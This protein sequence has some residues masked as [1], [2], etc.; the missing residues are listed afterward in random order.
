MP[1]IQ[2]PIHHPCERARRRVLEKRLHFLGRRRQ[3]NEVEGGSSDERAP[4]GFG[5]GP[6]TP[7][8]HARQQKRIHVGA[9]PS[10][11]A[12][13]GRRTILHRLESPVLAALLKLRAASRHRLRPGAAGRRL[14]AGIGR[15]HSHPLHKVGHLRW[16]QTTRGRHLEFLVPVAHAANEQAVVGFAG[17]HD[18][19]RR[20]PFLPSPAPI[21]PQPALLLGG[22]VAIQTMFGE[23][24]ADAF[25]KKG[26]LLRARRRH[27]P[28]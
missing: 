6:Y 8:L 4:V 21:Q 14:R 18:R 24:R 20:A 26:R 28:R 15:P 22:T 11:V 13:L 17:N 9:R 7:L 27:A 23:Q 10:A 19:A 3:P 25:F 16:G 1:R 12:N 2:K 5:S